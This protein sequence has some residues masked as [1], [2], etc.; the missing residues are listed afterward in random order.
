M[1]FIDHSNLDLIDVPNPSKNVKKHMGVYS[2]SEAS[3]IIASKGKI[4]VEKK[5]SKN[6]TVAVALKNLNL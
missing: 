5:K 6:A 3:A 2:V 1:I 4:I